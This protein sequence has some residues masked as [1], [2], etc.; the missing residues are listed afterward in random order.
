MI[1]DGGYAD[2][3]YIYSTEC[4]QTRYSQFNDVVVTENYSDTKFSDETADSKAVCNS[5]MY[6][7]TSD[8]LVATKKPIPEGLQ[9][10][11][12]SV[13]GVVLSVGSFREV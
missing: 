5:S 9:M 1:V 10:T 4:G 3:E 6:W 11:L 2:A 8:C 7:S 12:S 13:E